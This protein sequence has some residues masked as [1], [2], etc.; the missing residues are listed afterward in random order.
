MGLN[1]SKCQTLWRSQFLVLFKAICLHFAARC[2]R[3]AHLWPNAARAPRAEP[4]RAPLLTP[5]KHELQAACCRCWT[6]EGFGPRVG[7]WLG[8]VLGEGASVRMGKGIVT[9]YGGTYW[10]TVPSGWKSLGLLSDRS[11]LN[12][13]NLSCLFPR[14]RLTLFIGLKARQPS[15]AEF[16]SRTCDVSQWAMGGPQNPGNLDWY[17]LQSILDSFLDV[18]NFTVFCDAF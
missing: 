18:R 4:Y 14:R 8:W 3:Q 9:V 15:S 16:P 12:W 1:W 5:S 2:P 6:V 10:D 17:F 13:P 11:R 7:H